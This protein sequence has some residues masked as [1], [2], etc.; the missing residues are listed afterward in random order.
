[1]LFKTILAFVSLG[2][3]LVTST[4]LL[5]RRA[6]VVP[7]VSATAIALSPVG[8]GTYPR[9][10]VL[11][12]GSILAAFT[13]F[14]GTTRTLTVTRSTDGG[15]TFAAYGSIATGTGDLDNPY[16]IQLASGRVLASFRNHD[17][18]SAG[19]ATYYRITVCYS[20]TNGASWV[21]LSQAD[22]RAA[23]GVNGLWEPFFRIAQ[24]G[25]LQ[26]YYAQENSASDQDIWMRSSTDG[27]LTWSAVTT[28]AGATT[29]GRDGMPSC[30]DFL[31]SNASGARKTLCVF[32]TTEGAGTF[33][34][35]SVYSTNDGVSWTGRSPVYAPTGSGNNGGCRASFSQRILTLSDLLYAFSAQAPFIVTTAGG[36]L[37]VSFMTS[38]DT[39]VQGGS[40]SDM[41]I[42]ISQPL[43]P[44]VWGNKVTVSPVASYWPSLLALS[45]GTVL[46]CADNSGA[47]CYSISFS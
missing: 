10:L 27:G 44:Q 22:Q 19:V 6:T 32:E 11:H 9:E 24:S 3:A 40:G 7:T 13:Y 43:T 15:K 33:T 36:S 1:M 18:N 38:E 16:L 20:D 34:I 25:A 26:I 5:D 41:K 31:D 17:L 35:K 37:V 29:T 2:A 8:G 14:S 42:V 4:P 28:V 30:A 45:T 12:D 39:N 47:K 23:S 21:F 46:G